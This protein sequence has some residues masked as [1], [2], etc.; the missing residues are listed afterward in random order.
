MKYISTGICLCLLTLSGCSYSVYTH[1]GSL[2]RQDLLRER[3]RFLLNA[4]ITPHLSAEEKSMVLKSLQASNL[5]ATIRVG[6]PAGDTDVAIEAW[7]GTDG[8]SQLE[9][10]DWVVYSFM[11]TQFITYLPYL[12]A[13]AIPNPIPK[14]HDGQVSFKYKLRKPSAGSG[15]GQFGNEFVSSY[16]FRESSFNVG[17]IRPLLSSE[18]RQAYQKE[19]LIDQA[20]AKLVMDIQHNAAQLEP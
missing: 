19:K 5:F 7:S 17:W 9:Y 16:P 8:G 13:G 3:P 18:K 12:T 6:D 14:H 11:V 1:S 15:S 10:D 4:S 20:V 2:T